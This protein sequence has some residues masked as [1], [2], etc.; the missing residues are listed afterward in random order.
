MR[1]LASEIMVALPEQ[2]ISQAFCFENRIEQLRMLYSAHNVLYWF[3]L[4]HFYIM[5]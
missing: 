5:M 4:S 3:Q 1:Q 2:N